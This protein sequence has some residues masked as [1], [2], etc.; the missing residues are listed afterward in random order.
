MSRTKPP[1]LI[2][3]FFIAIGDKVRK[4]GGRAVGAVWMS[5]AK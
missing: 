4:L 3:T 2:L 5:Y 1:S